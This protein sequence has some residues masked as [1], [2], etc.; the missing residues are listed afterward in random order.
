MTGSGAGLSV[1]SVARNENYGIP[2]TFQRYVPVNDEGLIIMCKLNY[3]I[4]MSPW[5]H[6]G[7]TS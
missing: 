2:V 3:Y 5:R 4:Y 6:V 1:Q 7:M